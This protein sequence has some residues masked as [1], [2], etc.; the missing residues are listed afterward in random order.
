[1][2]L[3]KKHCIAADEQVKISGVG[4]NYQTLSILGTNDYSYGRR[5]N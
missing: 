5:V 4:M 3:W 1:M 2:N